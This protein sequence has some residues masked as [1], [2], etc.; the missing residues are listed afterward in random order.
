MGCCSL[1]RLSSASYHHKPTAPNPDPSNYRII[2]HRQV[3]DNL[4]VTIQYP[5]C[6]NYEGRKILVY[7]DM[8]LQKLLSFGKIDPHFSNDSLFSS[9]FARFEPTV[10]GWEYAILLASSL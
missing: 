10:A 5:D 4:V 7:R 2:K 6:T 1:F 9:P 8:T 3:N